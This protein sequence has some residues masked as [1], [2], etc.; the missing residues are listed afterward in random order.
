MVIRKGTSPR[1]R[2]AVLTRLLYSGRVP[3]VIRASH[4]TH[5]GHRGE[6]ATILFL[7]GPPLF[8]HAAADA[9]E[10]CQW[11]LMPG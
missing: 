11:R 1:Y 6:R 3:I 10:R 7:V 2:L 9:A 8:L 5:G 4:R